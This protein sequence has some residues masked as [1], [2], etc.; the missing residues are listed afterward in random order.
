[1]A[2]TLTPEEEIEPTKLVLPMPGDVM[3]QCS[4][5][6]FIFPTHTS[7]KGLSENQ[8][9]SNESPDFSG[10]E[11]HVEAIEPINALTPAP[12]VAEEEL[13][14][15]SATEIPAPIGEA[16]APLNDVIQEPD[17]TV[18]PLVDETS[19]LPEPLTHD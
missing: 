12:L 1:M 18:K 4:P 10:L 8:E 9:E 19:E 6:D 11:D 5:G 15:E 14:P 16:V 2:E 3:G 7:K 17:E 13:A